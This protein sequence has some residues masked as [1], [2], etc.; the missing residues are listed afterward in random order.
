M[1]VFTIRSFLTGIFATLYDGSPQLR[2]EEGALGRPTVTPSHRTMVCV[3]G[4]ATD[5]GDIGKLILRRT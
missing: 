2:L 4:T 3:C 1:P 5:A